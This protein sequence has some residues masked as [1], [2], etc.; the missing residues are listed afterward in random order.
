MNSTKLYL[1]NDGEYVLQVNP[2]LQYHILNGAV[3]TSNISVEGA[4][5]VPF[6][7][8]ACL[9][10]ANAI[11]AA[12]SLVTNVEVLQV[13]LALIQLKAESNS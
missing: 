6:Y 5:E 10:V 2:E 7:D 3:L 12:S 9:N 1:I 13:I 11:S 4:T 8:E